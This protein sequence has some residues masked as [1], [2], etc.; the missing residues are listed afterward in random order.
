MIDLRSDTVTKPTAEM[1]QLMAEAI[2]GDDVYGE[3]PTINEL[4]SYAAN[5][6]GKEKALFM[7]SGTQGNIAAILTHTRPGQEVIMDDE[8]HVFLYEGA[9]ASAFGGIQPR[10]LRHNRGQIPIDDLEKAI[11]GK[12]IHFPETALIWLENSHNRSGGSILPLSYV[13][14]VHEL[15]K[16][17]N[18]PVHVDGARIFNAAVGSN[19]SVKE[20]AQCAD[21]VQFCL[22]KGLGAPVGSILVGNET[23]IAHARKKRKMLGGGL[24]QSGVIAAPGLHGLKT[25]IHRLAEDH[26]HAKMLAKAVEDFTPCE[27]IHPVETNIVLIDTKESGKSASEWLALLNEKGVLAV[28]FAPTIIRLTTHLD[29][30]KDDI[31]SVITILKKLDV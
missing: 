24:R 1:R 12:D 15:A 9:G 28:A 23:F 22:S 3:D 10:A 19:T 6:F 13:R 29:I 11:R 25:G 26:E 16:A 5:L 14:E 21:T 7:T 2:V 8:S 17:Y 20:Y 30:S 18:I 27:V 4:E 31:Q